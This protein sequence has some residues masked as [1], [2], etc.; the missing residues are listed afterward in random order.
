MIKEKETAL[1][2]TNLCYSAILFFIY[3]NWKKEKLTLS[4]CGPIMKSKPR[5]VPSVFHLNNQLII[6]D[7][8]YYLRSW[9]YL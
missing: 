5:T 9:N 3:D 7:F 2:V 4:D 6:I 8:I 1:G